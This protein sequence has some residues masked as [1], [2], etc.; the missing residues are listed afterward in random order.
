MRLQATGT[1]KTTWPSVRKTLAQQAY[2][3]VLLGGG[4]SGMG[5][6]H[7]ALHGVHF[8]FGLLPAPLRHLDSPYFAD[9]AIFVCSRWFHQSVYYRRQPCKLLR[10]IF[11]TISYCH[12]FSYDRDNATFWS[13][14]SRC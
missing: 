10:Y 4:L 1:I 14:Q 6:L 7:P 2:I 5:L 3:A 12:D 9:S 13:C 8:V 11:I